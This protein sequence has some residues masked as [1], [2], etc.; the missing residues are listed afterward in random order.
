MAASSFDLVTLT[1]GDPRFLAKFWCAALDLVIGEDEDDG[2]WLMLSDQRG[3]RRLGL[4]RT[5]GAPAEATPRMHLDLRC[6]ASAFDSELIRFQQLGARLV[7]PSRLEPYGC[8][9]NLIDPAGHPFDLCAY[10]DPEPGFEN[11]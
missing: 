8:I 9:A 3:G 2:R 4:Q 11:P 10:D 6:R 5:V 7:E 1:C